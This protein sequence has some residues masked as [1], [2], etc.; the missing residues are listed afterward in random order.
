MSEIRDIVDAVDHFVGAVQ[1][2][3][4]FLPLLLMS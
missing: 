2:P 1:P 4:F 3:P